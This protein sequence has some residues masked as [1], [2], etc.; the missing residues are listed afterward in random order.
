MIK[1]NIEEFRKDYAENCTE[2][3]LYSPCFN[4]MVRFS[5]FVILTV[6]IVLALEMMNII[7]VIPLDSLSYTILSKRISLLTITSI[8]MVIYIIVIFLMARKNINSNINTQKYKWYTRNKEMEKI[9]DNNFKDILKKHEITEESTEKIDCIIDAINN[10]PSNGYEWILK[11]AFPGAIVLKLWNYFFD[12]SHD[13]VSYIILSLV[14]YII[15]IG[16]IIIFDKLFMRKR[17]NNDKSLIY[18]LKLL[19]CRKF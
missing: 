2:E 13:I 9:L 12:E 15:F 18:R 11:L 17:L 5:P 7:G 16:L 10:D 1:I 19:K 4:R 3:F 14:A 8:L 6:I